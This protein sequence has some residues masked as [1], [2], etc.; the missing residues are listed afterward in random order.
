MNFNENHPIYLQVI[1]YIETLILLRDW[2]LGRKVPSVRELAKTLKIN[3]GTVQKAYTELE[4]KYLLVTIR[5]VGKQVTDQKQYVQ[6]LREQRLIEGLEN[7]QTEM[8]QLRIE[9]EEILQKI[10]QLEW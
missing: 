4:K 2:E 10:Q 8:K 3:P 1:R 6:Q 5:G 7:F 9:K